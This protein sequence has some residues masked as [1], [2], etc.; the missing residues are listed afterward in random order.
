R[1]APADGAF[2][3]Y[4]DVSHITGAKTSEE[5]VYQLLQDIGVA[6]APG[7]DFDPVDGHRF[8]RLSFAGSTDDITEALRRLKGWLAEN[9]R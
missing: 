8:V 1:L 7:I 2:Y 9:T 5:L 4:A 6:L 3:V